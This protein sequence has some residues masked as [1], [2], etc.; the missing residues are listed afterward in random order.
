M[1]SLLRNCFEKV[2]TEQSGG[3]T[4]WSFFDTQFWAMI[5]HQEFVYVFKKWRFGTKSS[6]ERGLSKKK[7]QVFE[8]WIGDRELKI[9]KLQ[10]S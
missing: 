3:K 5:F 7:N 10:S 1:A 4:V 9:S 8:T 6:V 2:N